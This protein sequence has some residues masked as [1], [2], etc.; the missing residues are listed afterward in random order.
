MVC[1]CVMA[2][3]RSCC[4]AS[5]TPHVAPQ[6]LTSSQDAAFWPLALELKR[7]NA[8][9]FGASVDMVGLSPLV[10]TPRGKVRAS[11]IRRALR[12]R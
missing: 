9:A 7:T 5:K 10:Q 3:P 2:R 4:C 6:S 12:A 1:G 11:S 8:V